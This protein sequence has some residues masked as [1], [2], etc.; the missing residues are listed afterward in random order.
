[1]DI[2]RNAPAPCETC[3][4]TGQPDADGPCTDCGGTGTVPFHQ[5]FL[6]RILTEI[7]V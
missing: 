4:G 1:M 3:Q 5:T 6:Y 2:D 7:L